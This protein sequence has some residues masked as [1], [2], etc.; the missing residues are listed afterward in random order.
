MRILYGI[1]EL[2]GLPFCYISE[3]LSFSLHFYFLEIY[4]VR[5]L[6]VSVFE[7]YRL[8]CD[9]FLVKDAQDDMAGSFERFKA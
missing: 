8:T 4:F 5:T 7:I 1:W 9:R 6:Q 2:W 3:S